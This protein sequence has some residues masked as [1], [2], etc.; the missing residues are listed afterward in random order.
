[1][2]SMRFLALPEPVAGKI[3]ANSR[4]DHVSHA[5]YQFSECQFVRNA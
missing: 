5:E 1:M 3:T 4:K 2:L